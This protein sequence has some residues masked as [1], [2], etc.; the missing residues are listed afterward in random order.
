MKDAATPVCPDPEVA[1]GLPDLPVPVIQGGG[2]SSL[3]PRRKTVFKNSEKP[4]GL[5][6]RMSRPRLTATELAKTL[7]SASQPIYVLDDELTVV[8][9]NRACQEWLRGAYDGLVGVQCAYH[10]SPE[11]TG[12]EAVAAG[13]CPPPAA[14][15]GRDVTATVSCD[16]AE[17]PARHRRARFVPLGT[18]A[19]G[20][21]AVVALLDAED[22]P[23]PPD[24]APPLPSA[25][26][27]PIELHEQVRRFR[28][29]AAAGLRADRLIGDSPAIRRARAQIELAAGSRGSVLLVGPPGSGR[30]H[31][32]AAIHCGRH[33]PSSGSLIPLDCSALG[34]EL[35]HSTVTAL[36]SGGPL[37]EET[38][39]S[40]L[41]LNEAD[42]LPA[43]VQA[44]LV[45]VLVG[46]RFPLRLIATARQPLWELVRRGGYR[47]DLAAA[48]STI[49]IELPP[50]ARRRED[51]PRLAQLF[52]EEANARGIRQLGGFTPEALDALDAYPWP[53]NIDE[54][55]RMVSEAYDQAKGYYIGPDDL[56][57]RIHLAADAAACPRRP[58]ETIVLDR[59]LGEV[60]RELIRRAL[61][62][63]KGNKA[64]AAR[65]LGMTRPRLYRRLVQLG[66]T[67][68]TSPR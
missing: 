17:G 21:I 2:D 62:Q 34:A 14:V 18:S 55:A 47:E 49:T 15:S 23:E 28:Q 41:L 59:F 22:L 25:E 13:L 66:L 60:E 42:Q 27:G 36:A 8:F 46:K 33:G 29:Q 32:A 67:S 31:L 12:P 4:A 58:E 24:E 3:S 51:V 43:D 20:L 54:L 7:N 26:A 45:A 5:A 16:A 19:E 38:A 53:G 50:L 61:A 63:A 44:E 68:E 1:A 64:K 56:P 9:C 40:T 39:H 37:G 35:I 57:E 52:L 6:Q 48:L 30:Q 11:V 65:L 10:S